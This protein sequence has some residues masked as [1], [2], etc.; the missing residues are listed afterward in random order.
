MYVGKFVSVTVTVALL[1]IGV[2]LVVPGGPAG[3]WSGLYSELVRWQTGIGAFFGL[4]A[5]LAGVL[6]NAHHT[7]RRDDRLRQEETRALAVG[8]K[9]EIESVAFVIEKREEYIR[10]SIAG[11]DE[12]LT[13]AIDYM[14]LP[15]RAIYRAS[16][17][18]I[19]TIPAEIVDVIVTT[20]SNIDIL[21]S[22]MASIRD[23][24]ENRTAPRVQWEERADQLAK[25]LLTAKTA[26][27]RL[28][29]WLA[30]GTDNGSDNLPGK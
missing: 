2:S 13:S 5:I 28:D 15:T 6:Y 21:E 19:G 18:R 3:F 12:Q 4:I 24:R 29:A 20:H 11:D 14:A 16:V 26:I 30:G 17:G 22:T 10:E 1:L 27:A 25:V 23:V 7:R 9:L 8:L